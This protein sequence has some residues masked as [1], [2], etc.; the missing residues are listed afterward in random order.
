M[1]EPRTRDDPA[2]VEALIS[3]YSIL[4]LLHHR[5]ACVD[6]PSKRTWRHGWIRPTASGKLAGLDRIQVEEALDQIRPFAEAA[7]RL[8]Q[9]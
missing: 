4:S 3:S 8:K 9:A 1:D 2:L 7:C 5:G 6:Q